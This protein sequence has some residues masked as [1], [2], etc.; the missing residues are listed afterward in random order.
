MSILIC[1]VKPEHAWLCVDTDVTFPDGGR[2]RTS[3]ILPLPHANAAIAGRGSFGFLYAIFSQCLVKGGAE[4]EDMLDRMQIFLMETAAQVVQSGE[5]HPDKEA[6]LDGS[7]EIILAGWSK[8]RQQPVARVYQGNILGGI[9]LQ[10]DVHVN[11]YA[12]A[13]AWDVKTES[14]PPLESVAD[15]VRVAQSQVAR[16]RKDSP[17]CSAGGEFIVARIEHDKMTISKEGDL[18][19]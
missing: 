19:T 2:G 6:G 4:I 17:K 5:F 11:D 1:V 16:I 18:D 7:Q 13:P 10:T 14:Q 9:F 12:V 8:R 15:M 3:K